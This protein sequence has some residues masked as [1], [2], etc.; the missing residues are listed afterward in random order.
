MESLLWTTFSDA[1]LQACGKAAARLENAA[2]NVQA[3]TFYQPIPK[4]RS[5]DENHQMKTESHWWGPLGN[6]GEEPKAQ[7]LAT[8]A[9]CE[10]TGD[11][12]A[13]ARGG[14]GGPSCMARDR[15]PVGLQHSR[16]L[17]AVIKKGPAV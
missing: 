16:L 7:Q 9:A 2:S 13:E 3:V 6:G 17:S 1:A 11:P 10:A 4:S 8:E 15:D 5:G 12:A 14:G